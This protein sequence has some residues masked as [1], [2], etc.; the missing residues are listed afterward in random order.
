MKILLVG[1]YKPGSLGLSY[2]QSFRELGYEASCFDEIEEYEKASRFAKNRYARHIVHSYAARK[3]NKKLLEIAVDYEPDLVLVIKGQSLYPNSIRALKKQTQARVF[4]FNPDDPFNP[5]RGA[6][7]K[8]IRKSIPEYDCYI[9]WSQLLMPRIKNAGSRRVEYLPFA[10][11]AK[12]HFPVDLSE[13]DK[14]EY[15]SD[16]SFIGNWDDER[17]TWLGA[18]KDYNLAVWGADYWKTRCND[19]FIRSRW[20][21]RLA[22]G[23]EMSQIIQSAK[24]NLNILR[25]QN[26]AAHNM[27]TFEIPACGGFMLHERSEE[28]LEFFEEGKEIECFS[29]TEELKSKI[30]FYL[31]NDDVRKQIAEGGYQRLM[32]SGYCYTDRAKQILEFNKN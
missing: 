21:G 17:E 31:K 1:S 27:R 10:C 24:I 4:I 9:I 29:S 23:Q 16:V 20:K 6:S 12:L 26:K 13:E 5:N 19:K 25:L 22:I 3:M 11:D 2:L 32:K 18:L 8:I 7:N 14:S 30:R 15:G 28:L